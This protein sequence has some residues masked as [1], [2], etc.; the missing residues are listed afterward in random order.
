MGP[1]NREI[2]MADVAEIESMAKRRLPLAE[3]A[4]QKRIPYWRI[5]EICKSLRLAVRT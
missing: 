3:I 1:D 4:R 5:E 2:S